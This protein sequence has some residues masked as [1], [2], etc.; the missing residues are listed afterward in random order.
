M[1]I[2]LL[3]HKQYQY[4]CL[5]VASLLTLEFLL[6]V[7]MQV[8]DFQLDALHVVVCPLQFL[9]YVLQNLLS[10]RSISL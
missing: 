5:S 9:V 2:N 8:F 7:G 3:I 6:L 10:L 4:M 1:I